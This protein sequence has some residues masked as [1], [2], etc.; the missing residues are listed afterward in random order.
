MIKIDGCID[1]ESCYNYVKGPEKY[2][3]VSENILMQKH[4]TI[5]DCMY[6]YD[7]ENQKRNLGGSCQ[8]FER[9]VLIYKYDPEEELFD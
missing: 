4:P 7:C 8:N 5:P 6:F 3:G 2:I 1:M 9:K